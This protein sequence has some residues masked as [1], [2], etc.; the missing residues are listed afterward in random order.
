MRRI[1][2]LFTS[3]RVLKYLLRQ[4]EWK[5]FPDKRTRWMWMYHGYFCKVFVQLFSS[6]KYHVMWLHQNNPFFGSNFLLVY[7]V[8]VGSYLGLFRIMQR[9]LNYRRLQTTWFQHIQNKHCL[10]VYWILLCNAAKMCS[11]YVSKAYRL[12]WIVVNNVF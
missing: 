12:L 3:F 1:A 9:Q 11:L 5:E 7:S 4:N 8:Y 2:S 10:F 6:V